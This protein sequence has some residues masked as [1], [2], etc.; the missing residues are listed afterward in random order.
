M[1]MALL[2]IGF[3]NH[4]NSTTQLSDVLGRQCTPVIL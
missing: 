2:W 3:K 4:S 1:T